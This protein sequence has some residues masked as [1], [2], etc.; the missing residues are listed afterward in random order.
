MCWKKLLTYLTVDYNSWQ[1]TEES[2]KA[3]GH[4]EKDFII[5]E[6]ELLALATWCTERRL[7]HVR[8]L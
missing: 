7:T 1:E 4:L 8:R 6:G 2:K 5:A 3:L